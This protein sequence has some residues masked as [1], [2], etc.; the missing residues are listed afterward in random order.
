M[1][2]LLSAT[3][4]DRLSIPIQKSEVRQPAAASRFRHTLPSRFAF[5]ILSVAIVLSALAY[6]TV[7]YWALAAFTLGAAT[8]VVLW[9]ADGWALGFLRVSRNPL[10]LPVLGIL[11]LGPTPADPKRRCGCGTYCCCSSLFVA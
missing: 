8:M 4:A 9:L 6:G 3:E 10:Q 1:T 7:H 5:L 11:V 2:T